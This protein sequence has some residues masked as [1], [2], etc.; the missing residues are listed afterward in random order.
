MYLFAFLVVVVLMYIYWC[1]QTKHDVREDF[2]T[3][4]K[5]A[6][7]QVN[8]YS[9]FA[10]KQLSNYMN[11]NGDVD[12]RYTKTNL[13]NWAASNSNLTNSNDALSISIDDYRA[14]LQ[15]ISDNIAA[16]SDSNSNLTD[17]INE[18]NRLIHSV[19]T[20]ITT[21]YINDNVHS[22]YFS[23]SNDYLD[24]SRVQ[25][26]ESNIKDDFEGKVADIN[27]MLTSKKNV[28]EDL[29]EIQSLQREL[30]TIKSIYS[31]FF[32]TMHSM[33]NVVMV[34][35]SSNDTEDLYTQMS[36]NCTIRTSNCFYLS[37]DGSSA[38]LTLSNYG[39]SFDREAWPDSNCIAQ[40]QDCFDFTTETFE[41]S[42]N[43][44]TCYYYNGNALG[45]SMTS[46]NFPMEVS[47]NESNYS[48]VSTK[49]FDCRTSNQ[50]QA[51]IDCL[52]NNYACYA[53]SNDDNGNQWTYSNGSMNQVYDES[54]ETC[55]QS[56]QCG[57]SLGTAKAAVS[58]YC[59]SNDD[60][61]C[62]AFDS[63]TYSVT[64]SPSSNDG[65]VT[66]PEGQLAVYESRQDGGQCW[67]RTCEM[68]SNQHTDRSTLCTSN[69]DECFYYTA[70]G[71]TGS[72][73]ISSSNQPLTLSSD[74][75]SCVS[76]CFTAG[77]FDTDNAACIAQSNQCWTSTNGTL[78][79][80][81]SLELLRVTN[82]YLDHY[83]PSVC[84]NGFFYRI[85]VVVV[86]VT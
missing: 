80:S 50:V 66:F 41:C 15:T 35:P 69:T 72:G 44:E 71:T 32:S 17:A 5:R 23:D 61:V 39:Y 78:S 46:S 64:Q 11:S 40:D 62:Y 49:P 56:N 25:E 75:N 76:P 9:N 36:S 51:Q 38:Q 2:S 47:S 6:P 63:I 55:T 81:W 54:R 28:G 1:I 26:G 82:G 20:Y 48:C 86:V 27:A 4:S 34:Q 73:T 85:L 57:D 74:S 68:N 33:C 42:S 30:E 77:A 22:N 53:I 10:R 8:K 58:N 59:D 67:R 29:S 52:A 83:K 43:V 45:G 37:G 18:I 13:D 84:V 24:I 3:Q 21:K 14:R 19:E 16:M 31:N 79:S 60:D 12:T 65:T 7:K 70:S